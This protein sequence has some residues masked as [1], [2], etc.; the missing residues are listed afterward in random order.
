MK[1]VAL[2]LV[3]WLDDDPPKPEVGKVSWKVKSVSGTDM[4][5]LLASAA[6][7]LFWSS[8]EFAEDSNYAE[9]DPWS[10]IGASSLR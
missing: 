10:S 1:Y 5:I 2:A 3:P 4:N 7:M 6:K 8:V 9:D